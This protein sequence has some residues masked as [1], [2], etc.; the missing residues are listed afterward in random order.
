M[1]FLKLKNL[2]TH[3]LSFVLFYNI[4]LSFYLNQASVPHTMKKWWRRSTEK[5]KKNQDTKE[6][7]RLDWNRGV[8]RQ[9]IK[10]VIDWEES[11][12]NRVDN[13]NN[14]KRIIHNTW[15]RQ[16]FEQT[17][18]GNNRTNV[19]FTNV[20]S[21]RQNS[22]CFWEQIRKTGEENHWSIEDTRMS[23]IP[24]SLLLATR[25]EGV[26]SLAI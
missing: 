2:Q 13:I 26:S 3:M 9:L 11:I 7:R 5:E 18:I 12:K 24:K 6:T 25:A 8:S 10:Q 21:S 1:Q 20:L 23:V 22:F 15:H 16:D 19:L 17:C 14:R 4:Q